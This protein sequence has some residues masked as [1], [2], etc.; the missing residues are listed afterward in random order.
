MSN[1]KTT[2]T[3]ISNGY[4][5]LK[6]KKERRIALRKIVKKNGMTDVIEKLKILNKQIIDSSI[7]NL[8]SRDISYL[9][10]L[11]RK[12]IS[13]YTQLQSGGEDD[14][15]VEEI[16][17]PEKIEDDI[18]NEQDN[19]T[20]TQINSSISSH[21]TFH[22]YE[23]HVID[24]TEYIFYTLKETDIADIL[25]LQ[26]KYI[27]PN[28][29]LTETINTFNLKPNNYIGIKVN[30]NF[31]G[32]CLFNL[33]DDKEMEII[34]FYVNKPYGSTLYKLIER[35]ATN[36]GYNRIYTVVNI[37]VEYS[38]RLLNFWYMCGFLTYGILSSEHLLLLEKFV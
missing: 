7:K 19:K 21:N 24:S 8:Y 29:T 31:Q 38:I 13:K 5:T 26:R 23:K 2:Y 12:K 22:I 28:I 30:G 18:N 15:I 9:N 17:Y 1:H 4:S 32:Y 20:D 10:K 3:L 37:S 36:N 27:S 11:N 14:V 35:I 6:P 16:E 25:E 33:Q 34:E